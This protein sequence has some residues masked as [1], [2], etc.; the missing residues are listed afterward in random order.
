MEIEPALFQSPLMHVTFHVRLSLEIMLKPPF[1]CH[2]SQIKRFVHSWWV[3]SI[4]LA[5]PVDSTFTSP[6]SWPFARWWDVHFTWPLI[7]I[8]PWRDRNVIQTIG[9]KNIKIHLGHAVFKCDN[10]LF[11]GLAIFQKKFGNWILCF[12]L[13]TPKIGTV[14]LYSCFIV[15]LPLD[16][17]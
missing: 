5:F 10:I 9:D 4:T 3:L 14:C 7:Q 16:F 17:Y 11:F 13:C 6:S 12:L 15:Y 1:K 8:F 2:T